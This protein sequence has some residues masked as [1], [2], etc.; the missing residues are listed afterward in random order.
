MAL[1]IPEW[2]KIS[3]RNLHIKR[4]LSM[5]EDDYVVRRPIRADHCPADFFIAHEAKGWMGV[6]IEAA[7]FKEIGKGQ[8]FA[9]EHQIALER[10]L[11]TL[12]TLGLVGLGEGPAVPVPVL[13]LM[14][15]CSAQEVRSLAQEYPALTGLRWVSREEFTQRGALLILEA[16]QPIPP[17]AAQ[18]LL[19]TYFPE[20]EIAPACMTRRVFA[21]DNRAKLGRFFLDPQQEWASKLDLELPPEQTDAAQDCSVRLVNGVAGSGKTLIALHRARMLAE[22]FPAQRILVLIHNTPIVADIKARLYRAHGS[23]PSNLEITTFFAWTFQQWRALFS[24]YPAMPL[25]PHGLGDWLLKARAQMPELKHCDEQLMDEM[26]FINGALLRDETHYLEA[27][28]SGRG[29]ALRER[30]RSQLWSVYVAVTQALRAQGQH[31]W[32]ALPRELCLAQQGHERLLKYAHILVDEAQFFAPSWFHLVKHAIAPQGQ[33]FIC[34]DPNQGFMKSRLSWKSVGLE[35]AGRT[36]KLRTSY[37]TTRSILEAANSV[38][39]G[40]GRKESEDFLEPDFRGMEV[41]TRP[42]LIYTDSPQDAMDRAV[43]EMASILTQAHIPL[44]S[45]L[46]LYGDNVQK[47]DLYAQV[48]DRVGKD[49]VWW[50]NHKDQKKEP[51]SG[52]GKDYLRMAYLDTATGL[53]GSLVLMVGIESLFANDS[54]LGLTEEAHAERQ[55]ERARKL[56]MGLTRAGQKLVIVSCQKIPPS[57]EGLFDVLE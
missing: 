12:D 22:L 9:S 11:D 48:C 6:A 46:L 31:M 44:H 32:S 20:A 29:F 40:L 30:E 14:W 57:I 5:L 55:E 8:L 56:Y 18:R 43:N 33:I 13:V 23:I 37:R 7:N 15:T 2:V 52:Y 39:L 38:L 1:F 54:A 35:V 25:G 3:G 36:K 10:R 47:F 50:L 17:E 4:T 41:G 16:L 26:D 34:A 51:P 45:A 19:G 21:R 53:E 24:V 42:T 49:S 27:S 28:R